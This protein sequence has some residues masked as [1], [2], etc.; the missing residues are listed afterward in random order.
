MTKV[1][2]EGTSKHI[3]NRKQGTH[4]STFSKDMRGFGSGDSHTYLLLLGEKQL[5]GRIAFA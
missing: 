4:L 3:I 2:E 5:E 1:S